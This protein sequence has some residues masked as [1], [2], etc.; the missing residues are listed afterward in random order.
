MKSLLILLALSSAAF[1]RLGETLDQCT[2]RYGEPVKTEDGSTFYKK[3][4]I[5]I[6][7]HF[8]GDGRADTL[9]FSKGRYRPF[10]LDEV[11]VILAA[12]SSLGTWTIDPDAKEFDYR[13]RWFA[14]KGAL[15]AEWERFREGL[16]IGTKEGIADLAA[17]AKAKE[18]KAKAAAAAA[19]LKKLDGL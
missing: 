2:A 8:R 11:N 9:V 18:E 10:D 19:K 4:E 13:V 6:A 5:T 17:R 16:A 7:V 3:G 14:A 15:V 1:A 12:N